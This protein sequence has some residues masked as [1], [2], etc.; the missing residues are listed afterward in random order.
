[1]NQDWIIRLLGFFFV[2]FGVSIRLGY[3][4]NLY[5][6]S[7]GGIYGY[8]PMGLLFVL[9]SYYEDI[10]TNLAGYHLLFY[11][12]FGFLML[13]AILLT[14]KKPR[15]IKPAWVIWIEKY[16]QRV[17]KAMLEDVKNNP[18]WERNTLD[19]QAVDHWARKLTRK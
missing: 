1:M 8:I 3:W 18:E 16:P 7:K 13:S 6:A 5:W 2:L 17:R 14:I 19:E 10:I 11:V 4:R 15:W 9:Y 12:A